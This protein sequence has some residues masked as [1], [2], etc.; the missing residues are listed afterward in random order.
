MDNADYQPLHLAAGAW[1]ALWSVEVSQ[2]RAQGK[3]ARSAQREYRL[4]PG[5]P[6]GLSALRLRSRVPEHRRCGLLGCKVVVDGGGGF[7]ALGDCP[8]D[9]R[10]P[11]RISPAAKMPSTEVM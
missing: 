10:L 3:V 2:R 4:A 8:D 6:F 9:K 1:R 11:R 7:A 5:I